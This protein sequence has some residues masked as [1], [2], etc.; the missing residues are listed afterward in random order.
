[1]AYLKL[2][3]LCHKAQVEVGGYGVAYDKDDLLYVSDFEIVRQK[4]STAY[5]EFDDVGLSEYYE[6]M[7]DAK[8]PMKQCARLWFHTHPEMSANPSHTDEATFANKFSD[9][10]WSVMAILSKTNDT[11]A[12]LKA[13]ISGYEVVEEL[14]WVVDWKSLPKLFDSTSMDTLTNRWSDELRDLV[15]TSQPGGVCGDEPIQVISSGPIR[16]DN[17]GENYQYP[18]EWSF[19]EYDWSPGVVPTSQVVTAD[20]D[21]LEEDTYQPRYLANPIPLAADVV[22]QF[23]ELI[24]IRE[25]H[26]YVTHE[27]NWYWDAGSGYYFNYFHNEVIDDKRATLWKELIE[28]FSEWEW[29]AKTHLPSDLVNHGYYRFPAVPAAPAAQPGLHTLTD[30]EAAAQEPQ[31]IT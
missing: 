18:R 22:D 15:A 14:D 6:A 28:E 29:D 21:G 31:L 7:A 26:E 10:E 1:M 19:Q 23:P 20:N 25:F 17:G 9:S 30:S 27:D 5:M 4:S 13:N 16:V 11:S 3:Y 2:Q 8:V 12:R 24:A